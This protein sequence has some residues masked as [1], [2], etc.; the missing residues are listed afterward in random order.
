M[1]TMT[2]GEA[3]QIVMVGY[4]NRARTYADYLRR[5]AVATARP[6]CRVVAIVEPNPIRRTAALTTFGLPPEAGFADWEAYLAASA[7]R[8]DLQGVQA[9][10]VT[11][12]DHQHYGIALSALQERGYHVLLEKPI[13][14]SYRECLDIARVARQRNR[15]VGI[16]HPLRY[17]P[18][19]V[20]FRELA[21]DTSRIGRIVS[22][23]Y[24][25]NIG[26][27]RMTHAFVRGLWRNREASN[28]LLVSKCCHDIDYLVWLTG[29][30][31]T[32]VQTTGSLS[33]F[34]PERAPEA[35]GGAERCLECPMERECPFS[36]VELYLRRR[37]WLRHFDLPDGF[38]DGD[39][40]RVLRDT[41]YGRCV[42]RVGD[43]DVWDH[44]SV[45]IALADGVSVTLAV[46]GVTG[47][48]GRRIH[49]MGSKGE[50]WGDEHTIRLQRYPTAGLP[51][52]QARQEWHFAA[53]ADAPGHA[54]ADYAIVEDFLNGVHAM[55]QGGAEPRWPLCDIRHSMEAYRIAFLENDPTDDMR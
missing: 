12:P 10:I 47:V 52:D 19:F 48:E 4:G 16:C 32:R 37:K 17:H 40:R 24:A 42:Y 5:T 6:G 22:I 35:N 1:E 7:V 27:D 38:G 2:E 20:K 55:Q 44:Q 39:I 30:T 31:A 9:A 33:L 45:Q 8:I 43:N 15:I 21:R 13:A 26:L 50:L 25:E 53:L 49:V 46:N 41:S 23:S 29:S 14:Q 18:F 28:T 3:L 51:T 36:A 54:G 11:T 34:R